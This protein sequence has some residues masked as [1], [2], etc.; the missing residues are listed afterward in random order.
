MLKSV[1]GSTDGHSPDLYLCAL[2][3]TTNSPNKNK[4]TH[5]EIELFMILFILFC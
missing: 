1:I 3:E 4:E 5:D 2:V